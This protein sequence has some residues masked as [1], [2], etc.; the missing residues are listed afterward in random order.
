MSDPR[1][2]VDR[3]LYQ[4]SYGSQSVRYLSVRDLRAFC[5]DRREGDPRLGKAPPAPRILALIA[6][7][8]TTFALHAYRP[9]RSTS[10]ASCTRFMLKRSLA[11]DKCA[12]T[13]RSD[14]NIRS[15]IS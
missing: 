1:R 14:M 15:A 12:F 5:L 10:L 9:A 11:L 8:Q 13:V 4:R 6:V 3:R 7:P 2:H